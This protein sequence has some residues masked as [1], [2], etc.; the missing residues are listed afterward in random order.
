[1]T[2]AGPAEDK[3][4]RSATFPKKP[5]CGK[6]EVYHQVHGPRPGSLYGKPSASCPA[7]PVGLD[8]LLQSQL[9]YFDFED[10]IQKDMARR[11]YPEF[12]LESEQNRQY[13]R[14]QARGG[15]IPQGSTIPLIDCYYI[16]CV[17]L[18]VS[19]RGTPTARWNDSCIGPL[20][21]GT[22]KPAPGS[23][24]CPAAVKIGGVYRS[25]RTVDKN[26]L[27]CYPVP[28]PVPP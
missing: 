27:C 13:P 6:D 23:P 14:D 11:G 3:P 28:A 21:G 12:V 8:M 7:K 15:F 26:G 22:S 2:A 16:G 4:G 5:V 9:F 24:G 1:V 19:D 10:S 17:K 20:M 18:Q 25:F